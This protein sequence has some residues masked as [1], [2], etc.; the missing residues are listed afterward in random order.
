MPIVRDAVGNRLKAKPNEG[1]MLVVEQA[2]VASKG[3]L[4]VMKHERILLISN[5]QDTPLNLF[6]SLVSEP[7]I[8]SVVGD[9][10]VSN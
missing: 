6:Y 7:L 10:G 8:A 3:M 9:R 2:V 4:V 1:L 5:L